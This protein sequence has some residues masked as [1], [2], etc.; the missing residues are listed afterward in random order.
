M[1]NEQQVLDN[2]SLC[3]ANRVGKQYGDFK[4]ISVEYD[5]EK[6]K[7]RWDMVC[8]LCGK[9]KITYNG[10]D[11]RK[12]KN[13]GHCRCN[14]DIKNN[15]KKIKKEELAAIREYDLP[16]DHHWIGMRFGTWTVLSYAKELGWNCK[17][18]K[19]GNIRRDHPNNFKEEKTECFRCKQ[20]ASKYSLPEW[21]NKVF[22]NLTIFYYH[23]GMFKCICDC[24]EVVDVKP[25]NL[26]N[27]DVKTC[28]DCDYHDALTSGQKVFHSP[29]HER[30]YKIWGGMKQRCC[31]EKHK[32]YKYYG[33]RGISICEEWIN[34]SEAFCEWALSHGHKFNLSIDRI[35]NNGNYEPGNCRWATAK[36]QM[37]NQRPRSEFAKCL[38]YKKRVFWAIDGE[39]KPAIEWC[40]QYGRS[41]PSVAYRIK[42]TGMTV[43]E[44]L[45]APNK[46]Y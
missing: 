13:N 16:S 46:E 28:G 10:T 22:G 24:G 26:I 36:E 3:Y 38:S 15:L 18:E 33:G 40:N 29:E 23:R 2:Q 30:V 27:G 31:N 17:C 25:I 4:V 5:W 43:L 37:H 41:Y 34:N 14:T 9:H 19:C 45:T 32:S 20:L 7:Q 21:E 11:Y 39:T 1:L 6:R 12:G 8:V 35:N 42:K 44:A